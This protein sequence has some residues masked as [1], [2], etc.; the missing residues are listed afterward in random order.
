M[1]AVIGAGSGQSQWAAQYQG[2]PILLKG[3]TGIATNGDIPLTTLTDTDPTA[4]PFAQYRPLPGATLVEY[5]AS[6][7]P[8][9]NQAIAAN[10]I[11]QQPVNL[12]MLMLCPVQSGSTWAQKT[13]TMNS[14]VQAIKQHINLGG[15][16][17]A[18]TPALTYVSGILLRVRD[19]SQGETKQPQY[20]YQWDFYFPLITL[21]QAQVVLNT[22]LNKLSTGAAPNPTVPTV[23]TA[24]AAAN[25]TAPQFSQALTNNLGP[26]LLTAGLGAAQL[27]G[28]VGS[29]V[30]LALA[31]NFSPLDLATH[32]ANAYLPATQALGMPAGAALD[33]FSTNVGLALNQVGVSP[34]LLT[35]LFKAS[36]GS[37][38]IPGLNVNQPTSM[39]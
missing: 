18:V 10:A 34:T 23:T 24:L 39:Q 20:A 37:V 7:F 22:L 38:Q 4:P 2:S 8:F 6:T 17:N 36:L 12:S 14:L 15:L 1:S 5:Q 21:D 11:I 27:P 29:A 25:A 13:A 35:N 28:V 19:V 26:A 33:L 30:P 9:A 3:G 32:L 16:F 31:G